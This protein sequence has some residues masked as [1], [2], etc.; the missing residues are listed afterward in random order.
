MKKKMKFEIN[1]DQPLDEV[2][3]ALDDKGYFGVDLDVNYDPKMVI[4]F[5]DGEYHCYFEFD[6]RLMNHK[7]KTTTLAE[8]KEMK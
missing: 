6:E 4:A 7:Y 5:G 1:Q 8:L 3:S 2:Y